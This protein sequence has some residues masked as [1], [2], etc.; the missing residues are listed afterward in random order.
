MG[1]YSEIERRHNLMDGI[2]Q[3][4]AVVAKERDGI[5]QGHQL[6]YGDRD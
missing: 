1:F 4:K 3:P 2:G 5:G 6:R